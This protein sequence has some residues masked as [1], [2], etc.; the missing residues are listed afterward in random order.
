MNQ[1]SISFQIIIT[2]I[3]LIAVIVLFENTEFDI[4]IQ[5]YFFNF[6]TST[7]IINR[8]EPILKFLLYDGIKKVLI[9]FAVLIIISLIFLR[10]NKTI[11]EYKKGLLIVLFSAIIVPITIGSLKAV[12]NT[13]CPKNIEVFGGEYPN[14]KVFESYPS[15]F[16]QE[17]KVKC[18]PAGHASGGFALLSLFFLLKTKR[19]KILIISSSF[20]IAWSM[21]L[22]KMLI[23]DHYLSHT[24]ITMLIA[25]L[26]ILIIAKLLYTNKGNKNE[27]SA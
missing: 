11:I 13:P 9:F 1:K 3:L 19:N 8:D 20:I 22:Y 23:G 24:I 18:W 21:G 17:N 2:S 5:N 15:D 26:E 10:K 12:S 6:D 27:K 14:I 25:W 16:I 7:W 4:F